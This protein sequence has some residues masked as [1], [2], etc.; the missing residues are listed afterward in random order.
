MHMKNSSKKSFYLHSTA[1]LPH[2]D[3][4]ISVPR[5]QGRTISRPRQAHGIRRLRAFTNVLK[6][7]AELLNK[8]LG[9]EIPNLNAR[10]SGSAQPVTVRGEAQRVN[11]IT[12]IEGIEALALSKIPKHGN[13][14]LA[15]RGAQRT[16]RRNCDGVDIALMTGKVVAQFAVGQVPDLDELIPTSGDNDGVGGYRGETDARDPFSVTF[17]LRGNGILALTKSVPELDGAIAGTRDDLTVVNGEGN[18]EDILGV[19]QETTSGGAGV[20]IPKTKSAIPRARKAELAV[21]GDHHILNGV[22]VAEA[23]SL[24]EAVLAFLTG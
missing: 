18:G 22:A 11:N 7:R 16:I 15:T 9:L 2:T 8:T 20:D 13:A 14:I 12:S 21:G 19:A 5:V 10:L 24:R 4:S 23:A 1:D 3:D 17:R 6:I